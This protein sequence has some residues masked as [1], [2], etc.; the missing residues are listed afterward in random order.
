MSKAVPNEYVIHDDYF[1]LIIRSKTH[2]DF[3]IE[4]DIDDLEAIK[5][6]QWSIN[7]YANKKTNHFKNYYAS[8]THVG[9]LHRFL[10]GAKKGEVVDHVD[11]N[12]LNCR[13]SNLRVC[14]HLENRKNNPMYYTN[15]SGYTGVIWYTYCKTPKWMAYIKVDSKRKHLGYFENLE[16]AIMARREAEEKYFGEFNRL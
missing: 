3:N 14:T 9:F 5:N 1:E 6:N 4:I 8:N 7:G 11:G 10:T 13:R 12:P 16:D 15:K 2:G